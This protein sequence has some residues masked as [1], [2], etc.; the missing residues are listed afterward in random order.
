MSFQARIYGIA[1]LLIFLTIFA[2][3]IGLYGMYN[4]NEA[5]KTEIRLASDVS[6]LKDIKSSMQ[7]VLISVREIVLAPTAEQ[8][9]VEKSRLD[10]SVAGIDASLASP[11]QTHGVENEW[12]ALQELWSKHK[13]IIER[14]YRE[15]E[16]NSKVYAAALAS[17]DSRA[18]WHH[19]D[20]PLKSIFNAVENDASELGRAT[21][22]L[23]TQ[24]LEGVR[25][26]EVQEKLMAL[27]TNEEQL[28]KESEIGK[29][30]LA[31]LTAT[32]NRL[33]RLLTNP[34]VADPQLADFGAALAKQAESHIV[35]DKGT[36]TVEKSAFSLPPEFINPALADP[37]RIY[38]NDLKPWR[39]NGPRI[40]QRVYDLAIQNS[41]ARAFAILMEECN[42]TRR[43]ESRLI[44]EVVKFGDAGLEKAIAVA[45]AD[46]RRAWFIL[47]FAG[48]AAIVFGAGLAVYS[49]RRLNRSLIGAISGLSDRSSDV[50]QIAG[51]MA[52]GANT[53]AEGATSQASSLEETSSALEQM[54]SMTRQNADSAQ[55]TQITSNNSL[56]LIAGGS[57]TVKGVTLAMGEIS[58]ASEKIS[59]IIKTIEGI[60]FQTN[61]LALN[62]AVEAARAGEAGKGFAVVA[63]EVRHLAMRSSQAAKETSDLI[64]GTVDRIRLGSEQVEQLSES[65]LE[66]EREAENVGQL[67]TQISTATNEQALGVEQVN[68]AVAA[69]D[70]VTQEN[71]ATAEESAGAAEDLSGQAKELLNLVKDLEGIVYG[72]RYLQAE[73]VRKG[74]RAVEKAAALS[75]AREFNPIPPQALPPRATLRDR[76]GGKLPV[77]RP[78]EMIPVEQRQGS[79]V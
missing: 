3:A 74:D 49:V 50:S 52:A 62:A 8:K 14:I 31:R 11:P 65:F 32:L 67:V 22:L 15:S 79:V 48:L 10:Q 33:E 37:S 36:A 54:A 58:Q 34:A 29:A 75:E 9:A 25:S 70:K 76:D 16:A 72:Q 66:I 73:A 40:F 51:Q 5:M 63:D 64:Q 57:E 55:K 13:G 60:A 77:M 46:Y 26:L 28:Q 4:I 59:H 56:G 35:F 21:A 42:P 53:L 61:L 12:A 44:T 69:M 17:G 45:K 38:W 68:K 39:G 18:F 43:E 1:L 30:E 41:N 23:A 78:A 24:S 71:A 47:A 19:Y 7:D 2:T 27:V 6:T 20:V